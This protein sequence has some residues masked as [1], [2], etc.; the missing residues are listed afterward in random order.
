[1]SNHIEDLD[2]SL[3][4]NGEDAILRRKVGNTTQSVTVRAHVRSY[5][6]T[7]EQLAAGISQQPFE[8]RISPT[9]IKAAGWPAGEVRAA[10]P[11]DVDPAIPR[12]G[13]VIIIKGKPLTVR[14]VDPIAVDNEVVRIEMLVVG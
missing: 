8:V 5:N 9:Q 6:L 13:D 12:N 1:M 2:V 11:Y 4:E 14:S 10:A 3:A 7:A